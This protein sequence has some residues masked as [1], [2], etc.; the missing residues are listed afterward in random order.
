MKIVQSL[1][2]PLIGLD[3]NN[4]VRWS[5]IEKTNFFS[6]ETMFAN[7][8]DALI[9]LEPKAVGVCKMSGE[10]VECVLI[11]MPLETAVI[12][13]SSTCIRIAQVEYAELDWDFAR[14]K[15]VYFEKADFSRSNN[16]MFSTRSCEFMFFD[17]TYR[18]DEIG[19]DYLSFTLSGGTYHF[20]DSV[21]LPDDQTGLLL[22]EIVR[23]DNG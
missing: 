2:G 16:V 7:D 4:L 1:G 13:V 14:I 10:G 15:P 8:Y 22:Y 19:D 18:G 3:R 11:T 6:N 12:S 21:F 9:S 17:A 5:G 20:N 23:A